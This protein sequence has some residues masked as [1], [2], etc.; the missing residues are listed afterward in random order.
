[1]HGEHLLFE[2][3]AQVCM[4]PH[5]E[6]VRFEGCFRLWRQAD[7]RILAKVHGDPAAHPLLAPDGIL[8]TL[9]VDVAPAI[10]EGQS[11]EISVVGRM[12]VRFMSEAAATAVV[13]IWGRNL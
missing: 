10:V 9:V 5:G 1:M 4:E 13:R 6:D 8:M 2:T 11:I 12:Y 7:G 3:P